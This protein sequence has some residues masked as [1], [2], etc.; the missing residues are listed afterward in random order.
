MKRKDNRDAQFKQYGKG[1]TKTLD[2]WV[3]L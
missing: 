2:P 1:F 3:N